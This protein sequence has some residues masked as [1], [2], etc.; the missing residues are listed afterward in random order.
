M[1]VAKCFLGMM[2]GGLVGVSLAVDGY[3][4]PGI[5]QAQERKQEKENFNRLPVS[6]KATKEEGEQA[7][8]AWKII[9]DW[10]KQGK[11]D[12]R[13]LH[14]VYVTLTDRAALKDYKGRLDRIVRNIQAYYS[15]QMKENGY[16][17]LTFAL[18]KDKDGHVK[19]HTA[20]LNNY[21]SDLNVE[22]AG[23]PARQA[24]EEVLRKAGV[25]P[26]REHVL[27]VVQMPDK[28]GPYYGRGD[29]QGGHA[30]VC[31]APHL[32]AKNLDSEESGNYIFGTLGMDNT[33]YIG[34]MAHVLGNSFG[35]SHT[36]D[37][38][39]ERGVS[40]TGTGN[41]EYGKDVRKEGKGG[42]LLP[43]DALQLASIPLFTGRSRAVEHAQPAEFQDMGGAAIKDG[44]NVKGKVKGGPPVY[45]VVAFFDPAGDGDYDS[46]AVLAI[47]DKD[48]NFELDITRPG[49][50]GIFEFRL[51]AL[52][53]DGSKVCKRATLLMA[54]EGI[55]TAPLELSVIADK[56]KKCWMERDWEGADAALKAVKEKYGD[57][58]VYKKGL[59]VW[60][61]AVHPLW[62]GP[63]GDEPAAVDEKIKEVSLVD[64]KPRR[65]MSGWWV[66][67]W[68]SLPCN[69]GGP[70]A[71]FA[72]YMPKRF[73]Y[74]HATGNFTYNLGGKWKTLDAVMGMPVGGGGS[75]IIS[76]RQDGREVYLSPALDEGE[77]QPVRLDL[78]GVDMLSIEVIN[79]P[80]SGR[81]GNWFVIADPVLKR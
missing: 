46:N 16:P 81:N 30:C 55:N 13:K 48:G 18:D 49:Y 25:N 11:Q 8:A 59:D 52:Q 40:L 70:Y 78:D 58:P 75:V 35:L 38:T 32:D 54:D 31:D 44:M 79:A 51:V 33:V 21:M 9:E 2:L 60:D 7:A 22:T 42:Y 36:S 66:P 24:A 15:D 62:E 17:P 71:R 61:K 63:Q 23:E 73:M 3:Q 53:A 14:V 28:K 34:G 20:H 76:I 12:D 5:L 56:V 57:N 47:P 26:D 37:L 67:F 41:Y 1:I 39:E 74:T 69:P 27:V 29:F 6:W 45:G 80:G 65:V 10:Q 4:C 43:S 68:D 77:S 19:V 64:A 50:K 72:H